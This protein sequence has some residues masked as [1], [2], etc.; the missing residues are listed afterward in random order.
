[1]EAWCHPFGVFIKNV[2]YCYNNISP[3]GFKCKTTYVYK[4]LHF[5]VKEVKFRKETNSK[6]RIF[7]CVLCA[8]VVFHFTTK[9]QRTRG[10]CDY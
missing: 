1:M 4:D 6:S 5:H 3:S 7:L 10:S 9:T 8:S 2:L